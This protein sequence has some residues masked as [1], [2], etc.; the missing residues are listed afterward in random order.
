MKFT[1]LSLVAALAVSSAVA[2]GDITPAPAPEPVVEVSPWSFSG[3]AK[4][5]YSTTD[6]DTTDLF[7]QEGSMGQAAV[8][9]DVSYS[10]AS[11]WKA[12]F[13]MTGIATLGLD[14]NVVGG[15]WLYAGA[16]A[17]DGSLEFT[18]IGDAL[19]ID[20]ANIT[21]TAFDGKATFIL[22]RTELD[23]P[24][25]F[26]ETWNIANNTFDAAVAMVNP[27]DE[28]TV[29]AGYIY[30]GNGNADRISTMGGGF[31]GDR[32][33]FPIAGVEEGAWTVAAIGKFSGITAQA[34]YYDVIDVAQALW[35]QADGEFNGFTVGLQYAQIDP[36]DL[37]NA[38]GADLSD[39]ESSAYAAKIG[40]EMGAF[41]VWAAYSS[42]DDGGLVSIANTATM[43]GSAGWGGGA[44]QSK[45]YTEAWWNYGFVSLPGAD[46]FA[47]AGSY[48]VNDSLSLTAQYTSV[49]DGL[50]TLATLGTDIDNYTTDMNELTLLAETSYHGLD[51]AIAYIYSDYTSNS[52]DL[53]IATADTYD[54]NTLQAYI[55]YKF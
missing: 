47:V 39:Y 50:M 51:I 3:D 41:N 18:S 6:S 45:L 10:F 32:G 43:V 33:Y 29:V 46:S 12:N 16:N 40:Y 24:L 20:T 55:T 31:T 23:T 5:F 42:V 22:G 53:E 30:D 44:A 35:L 2:G 25:A 26:T 14:D 36:T 1:K 48:K 13:G 27:I 17:S 11:T 21:G 15:V 9:A 7:D 52:A 37:G 4:F 8:S 28:L 54:N 34:W 38:L 19:W 49:T